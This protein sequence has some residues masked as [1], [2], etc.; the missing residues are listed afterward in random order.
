MQASLGG[1]PTR[2]DWIKAYLRLKEKDRAP[3]D[4]DAPGGADTTWQLIYLC[5]RSGFEAEA[6]AVR[7]SPRSSHLESCRSNGTAVSAE[8]SQ[9]LD[10]LAEISKGSPVAPTGANICL[11]QTPD[12]S[13]Y[14][15]G[16]WNANMALTAIR[17]CGRGAA[18]WGQPWVVLWMG[19]CKVVAPWNGIVELKPVG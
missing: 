12:A 15:Q 14:Q 13:P 19:C 1:S 6:V 7:R 16:F 9:A 5:L 3:L 10:M 2:L 18:K 8:D 11:C 4:F 17:H